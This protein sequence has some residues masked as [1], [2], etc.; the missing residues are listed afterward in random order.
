MQ[1]HFV[2]FKMNRDFSI[3]CNTDAFENDGSFVEKIK[4]EEQKRQEYGRR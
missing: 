4:K 1:R 3:L 2:L